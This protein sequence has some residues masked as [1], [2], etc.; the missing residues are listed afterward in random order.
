MRRRTPSWA[1]V[2]G[3]LLVLGG[4]I[5]YLAWTYGWAPAVTVGEAAPPFLLEDSDGHPV[6]VADYLGR[7]PVVLVFYMTYG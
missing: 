5:S 6:N 7:K 1:W 4:G 2:V 3:F